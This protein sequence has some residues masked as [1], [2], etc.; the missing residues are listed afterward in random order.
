MTDFTPC[1]KPTKQPKAQPTGKDPA[2]LA[3]VALL[4]C[5]ICQAFGMVQT[6][7]TTV[8]HWII[9]RPI[10]NQRTPDGE[11]IP[12][13]EHHHQARYGREEGKLPIHHGQEAWQAAYGPDHE[14][15]EATINAVENN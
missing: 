5:C 6:S 13:C 3:K 14:Y 8:H 9:D 2:Y 15:I 7:K 4:P 11:A 10:P 12:L 1:P